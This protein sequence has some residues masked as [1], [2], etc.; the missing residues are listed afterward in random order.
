M[1][2]I[3]P[4]LESLGGVLEVKSIPESHCSTINGLEGQYESSGIMPVKNEGMRHVLGRDKAYAILKDASFREPP[5]PT[6]YLV[7]EAG[8]AY[9]DNPEKEENFLVIDQKRYRILGEEILGRNISPQ[10]FSGAFE[11]HLDRRTDPGTPSYFILPPVP[12]LELED[13]KD[14]LEIEDIISASPSTLSDDFIREVSGFSKN[15]DYATILVGFNLIKT[16][17]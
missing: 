11:Y 3:E 16:T 15:K 13:K 7:E 2:K 14:A 17:R 12:F 1:L 6:V 8:N 9:D 4:F 10:D 5:H